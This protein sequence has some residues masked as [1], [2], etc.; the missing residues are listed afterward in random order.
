MPRPPFPHMMEGDVPLFAAFVLSDYGNI[1]QR[2]VFDLHVGAG[3]ITG[4]AFD[5]A[6]I[7]LA[8]EVSRLRIDAVG[9][10]G[11]SPTIFEVKPSAGLSA[12]GQVIGY[13]YFYQKEFQMVPQL[14][15]ITDDTTPD[16]RELYAAMGV[17]LYLVEPVDLSGILQA[18]KKV[19]VICDQFINVPPDPSLD[20]TDT[21]LI[22]PEVL[23][24][25]GRS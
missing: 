22:N 8:L 7:A 1:Y 24:Y 25:M 21:P 14:G 11:S 12:L 9:Y 6:D 4:P 17:G 13:R 19:N 15:I 23:Y 10:I 18:C 16:L 5:P 20:F 3:H 2:W